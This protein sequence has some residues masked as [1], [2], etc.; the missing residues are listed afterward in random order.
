MN[1]AL[2]NVALHER[3]I[4][5]QQ[6]FALFKGAPLTVS[7]NHPVGVPL[8]GERVHACFRPGEWNSR[9][10]D[11]AHLTIVRHAWRREQHQ[12]MRR[13]PEGQQ[14]L[15]PGYDAAATGAGFIGPPGLM[16]PIGLW[17]HGEYPP[18][19]ITLQ[20]ATRTGAAI[21]G[22]AD[23]P[24][25]IP[26]PPMATAAATIPVRSLIFVCWILILRYPLYSC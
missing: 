11:I 5:Q 19:R 25:A 10:T 20:C 16:G 14:V 13:R 8:R 12:P 15:D 26:R 22:L 7:S 23:A 3:A 18:T 21:A 24:A 2:T 4:G 6:E 1:V 17:K 9:K